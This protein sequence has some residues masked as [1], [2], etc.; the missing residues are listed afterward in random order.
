MSSC[1]EKLEWFVDRLHR[2][3]ERFQL[4]PIDGDGFTNRLLA[5]VKT[6]R[7]HADA[8]VPGSLTR[9][10]VRFGPRLPAFDL[11]GDFPFGLPV[12]G[13]AMQR[14]HAISMPRLFHLHVSQT[15]LEI[16]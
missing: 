5:L 10:M 8:F 7:N 13:N 15:P 2:I 9:R 6:D 14:Q 11:I 3:D 1:L 16:G 12:A 4:V